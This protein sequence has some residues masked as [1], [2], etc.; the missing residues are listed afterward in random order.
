MSLNIVFILANGEDTD[1]MPYNVAFHLGLHR[2][3]KYLFAGT[4]DLLEN[5]N[6]PNTR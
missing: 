3:A 5:L 2:L 4:V 6:F 1:E